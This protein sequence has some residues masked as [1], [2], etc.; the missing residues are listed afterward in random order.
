MRFALP[1]VLLLVVPALVAVVAGW[2]GSRRRSAGAPVAG[3]SL[4]AADLPP[5]WRSR[6]RRALPILRLVGLVAVVVALA[7]PQTVATSE[8]VT[9]EGIDIVLALD[10]SGSMLSEDF[11]PDNRLAV[12]K[13]VMGD[14]ISGRQADRIGLVVFAG[15]SYTQCPLTLDYPVVEALLEQVRFG[16]IDDGTAIG[17]AIA[18]GVNRLTDSR[19]KSR[20]LVLLTDGENNAGPIDPQTAAQLAKARGIRVYTIGVGREGIARIPVADTV[21][22]RQYRQVETHID[23]ATLREIADTTGGRYFRADDPESLANIFAT[24]DKL[25]KTEVEVQHY[26]RYGELFPW[27]AGAALA[28]LLGET[29]L[30]AGPL[31]GIP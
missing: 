31:A 25:E 19:A 22:G 29:L 1:L 3:L 26:H 11:Q 5:T 23:E 15:E 20:I 6:A 27:A 14:F 7:R 16:L 17:M 4:I 30:R 21:F 2:R 13:R 10:I 24:I 12:A 28:L 18:N 8:R 9:S